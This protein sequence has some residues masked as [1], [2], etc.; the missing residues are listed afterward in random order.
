[1]DFGQG[2][3]LAL[4]PAEEAEGAEK[5]SGGAGFRRTPG[6][7]GARPGTNSLAPIDSNN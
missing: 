7:K 6:G 2:A 1:M 3:K 4:E 5:D